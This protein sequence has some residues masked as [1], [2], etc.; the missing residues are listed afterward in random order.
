MTHLGF[1]LLTHANPGQTARLTDRL[2]RLYPGAPIVVHH[3]RHQCPLPGGVLPPAIDLVPD[4]VRTRWGHWSLVEATLVG[5]RRMLAR[6]DA[7]EW[8][9]LLSGAD[10]PIAHPDRVLAELGAETADARIDCRRAPPLHVADE[11]WRGIISRYARI[12]LRPHRFLPRALH[13][14]TVPGSRQLCPLG[15]RLP[16]HFGLHWMTVNRRAAAAMLAA[17]RTHRRLTA[18]MRWAEIPEEAYFQTALASTPGLTLSP[19]HA[20]FVRWSGR[21]NPETLTMSDL[22]AML[23]SG[24]HFARKFSP[25]VDRTVLDALDEHLGLPPFR[26]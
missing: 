16:L 19:A 20:R 6:P 13:W 8:I 12:P 15:A 25:E 5:L 14:R 21:P 10:Y 9:V 17:P 11:H 4:P 26:G 18:W 23:A 22:P 24:D 3:D 7:P 2:L 1:L